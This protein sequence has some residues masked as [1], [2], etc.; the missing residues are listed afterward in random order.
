MSATPPGS[1]APAQLKRLLDAKSTTQ[2]SA[3]LLGAVR[4]AE[5]L[6]TARR[7]VEG[8]GSRIR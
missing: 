1:S 3:L 8:M 2:Y 7:L 5:L 4:A 6:A